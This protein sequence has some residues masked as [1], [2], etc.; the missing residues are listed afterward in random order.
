M[1]RID[2]QANK[3]V[4][5]TIKETYPWVLNAIADCYEDYSIADVMF[6]AGTEENYIGV[7]LE[8]K[9][10]KG[11]FQLK[12]DGEWN[13]YFTIG[14][15][16]KLNFKDDAPPAGTPIYFINATDAYGNYE[17]GKYQK[18]LNHHACLAYLAPDGILIF[19]CKSLEEAFCGYADYYVRH[20]TEYGN[21]YGKRLWETK[22]VL[23]LDKGI[24]IPCNPPLELFEK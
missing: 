9:T 20:T 5:K 8:V 15:Y 17:K 4:A 7:P 2:C 14:I 21:K 24:Y 12:Y 11:G 22:S 16:N 19:S 3:Y 23:N 18:L 6:S 13:N 1:I 10:I